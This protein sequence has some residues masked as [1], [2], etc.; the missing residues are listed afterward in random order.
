MVSYTSDKLAFNDE[1]LSECL[2][3]SSV[4]N[5]YLAPDLDD[6]PQN[7]ERKLEIISSVPLVRSLRTLQFWQHPI[8]LILRSRLHAGSILAG[9]GPGQPRTPTQSARINAQHLESKGRPLSLCLQNNVVTFLHV[10]FLQF[11]LKHKVP[12]AQQACS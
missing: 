10:C 7:V 6:T 4:M 8:S 9:E 3:Y 2:E 1:N 12:K 11:I 5:N